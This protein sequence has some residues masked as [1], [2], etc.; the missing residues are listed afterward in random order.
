MGANVEIIRPLS[1]G[2]WFIYLIHLWLLKMYKVYLVYL[3]GK[4]VFQ[5]VFASVILFMELF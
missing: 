4:M 1:Y 5:V 2:Q 3:K